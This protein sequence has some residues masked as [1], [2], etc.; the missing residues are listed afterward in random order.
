MSLFY[1]T[2]THHVIDYL[3]LKAAFPVGFDWPVNDHIVGVDA[4]LLMDNIN[5][6]ILFWK[7]VVET[8][9]HSIKIWQI[10]NPYTVVFNPTTSKYEQVWTER[11]RTNLEMIPV[12]QDVQEYCEYLRYQKIGMLI[13]HNGLKANATMDTQNAL[14]RLITS[15]TAQ[16][17]IEVVDWEGVLDEDGMAQWGTA[18]LADLQ[19]LSVKC[20]INEQKAFTAKRNTISDHL[21][22]YVDDYSDLDSIFESYYSA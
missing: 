17:S 7:R 20:L 13:E 14:T 16:G 2:S 8:S 15:I 18:S 12:N 6:N 22:D 3:G 10:F 21:S 5:P 1:N 9:Q 19:A 11:T 4:R